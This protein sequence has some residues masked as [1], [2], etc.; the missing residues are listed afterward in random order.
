M[1]NNND[2]DNYNI[3]LVNPDKH[4]SQ[5]KPHIIYESYEFN[6]CSAKHNNICG[7]VPDTK[8]MIHLDKLGNIQIAKHINSTIKTINYN[9]SKIPKLPNPYFNCE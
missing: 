8:N 3:K 2:N 4:P 5:L 7:K 9:W 6:E 1:Y